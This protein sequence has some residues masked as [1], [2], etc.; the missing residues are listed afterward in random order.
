MNVAEIFLQCLC[1]VSVAAGELETGHG[2]QRRLVAQDALHERPGG[3][4]RGR[5][6]VG[7]VIRLEPL[8]LSAYSNLLCGREP[9]DRRHLRYPQLK[10]AA[11]VPR[12]PKI[13]PPHQRP[14]ALRKK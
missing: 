12:F 8:R 2:G 11:A 1:H 10:M 3:P 14:R 13:Q 9:T 7:A 4:W 5:E 6:V